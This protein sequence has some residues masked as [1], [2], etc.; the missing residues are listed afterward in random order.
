MYDVKTESQCR[1]CGN[2]YST[3]GAGRHLRNCLKKLPDIAGSGE[4]P[5]LV[6]VHGDHPQA[7]GAYVL[8]AIFPHDAT[9]EQL[10][11]YLR[12][13]WL[14]C[15]A[16]LSRFES[17]G[18]EYLGD[19]WP[20]P[21]ET[22][23]SMRHRIAEAIGSGGSAL[24][25]YD[26]GDTT[27]LTVRVETA[28]PAATG[29]REEQDAAPLGVTVMRNLMP[30]RCGECLG[31]ADLVDGDGYFCDGCTTDENVRDDTWL[32]ANSPRDGVSCFGYAKGPNP[33]VLSTV[34]EIRRELSA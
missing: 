9:L 26:M 8:F 21:E 16:H 34:L 23:H 14:E 12:H 13:H 28:P 17:A 15:C 1:L 11:V 30:E 27:S 2:T 5:L 22:S 3:R 24:Y 19:E 6:G 31:E 18:R 29:W 32:L 4:P 20:H 10:D 25:E 7:D 33:R